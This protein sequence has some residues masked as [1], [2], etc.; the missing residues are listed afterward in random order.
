[1]EREE[2]DG[3][4]AAAQELLASTSAAHLAYNAIEAEPGAW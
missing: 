2:I 4:L 1:M 3:E